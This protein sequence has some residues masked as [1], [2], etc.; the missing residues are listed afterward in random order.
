MIYFMRVIKDFED[1]E[2][3]GVLRTRADGVFKVSE[4]RAKELQ[5]RGVAE[6]AFGAD[7]PDE[8]TEEEV[9]EEEVEEKSQSGS[10]EDKSLSGAPENQSMSPPTEDKSTTETVYE[11]IFESIPEE[12]DEETVPELRELAEKL[13]IDLPNRYVTKSELIS[14]IREV[15]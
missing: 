4:K 8:E 5:N 3:G 12:L 9:E 11:E 13:E 10:P 2:A 1:E 6:I 14:K 7:N 15:M